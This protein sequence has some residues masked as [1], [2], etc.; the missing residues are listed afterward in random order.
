M[1]S[2]RSRALF[3]TMMQHGDGCG[4]AAREQPQPLRSMTKAGGDINSNAS[5]NA[6]TLALPT[7]NP[8]KLAY[9]A[10]SFTVD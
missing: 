4:E 10:P 6:L 7:N 3:T 1:K 5:R 9:Q 2:L 8:C